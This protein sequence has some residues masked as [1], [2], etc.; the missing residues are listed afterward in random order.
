LSI[1]NGA[2]R[3]EATVA[4]PKGTTE[5]ERVVDVVGDPVLQGREVC[6]AAYQGR[7]GCYDATSGQQIWV[8]D[9]STLTGTSADARYCYVSEDRGSV[10]AFD[11]S[12]GRSVWKQDRLSLR[13]L[14]LP[15]PVEN[16]V[17]V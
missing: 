7:V 14:T 10:Q 1:A 3:W 6:A 5:L 9:I 16:A 4:I 8:R 15:T 11:R 12:S 13:E 2:V 17:A